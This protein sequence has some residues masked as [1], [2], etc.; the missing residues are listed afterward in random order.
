MALKL[1]PEA[2]NMA[3]KGLE[4]DPL[5]TELKKIG[6]KAKVIQDEEDA[7]KKRDQEAL[8]RSEVVSNSQSF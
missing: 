4:L 5:N 1:I 3:E 7:K 2:L 6:D 8:Q